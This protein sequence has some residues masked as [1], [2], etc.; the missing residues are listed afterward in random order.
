M[1]D[2]KIKPSKPFSSGMEYEWFLENFCYRCK[3]HKVTKNGYCAFEEQG[4]C[5]YE[6][7]MEDARWDLSIFPCDDIVQI[8]KNGNIV[9]FNACKH[10][11][12]DDAELMK[13][14]RK[15]FEEG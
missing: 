1:A 9:C 15:L 5:P 6:N 2:I 8:E 10:F 11:E 12:S 13:K 7:A 14:Y 4:G 3:K